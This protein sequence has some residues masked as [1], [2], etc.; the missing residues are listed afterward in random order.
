MNFK[1]INTTEFHLWTDVLHAKTLSCQAQNPWDRG[2]YVRWCIITGWTV[3]E[4]VFRQVLNDES[5]GY[6]FKEDVDRAIKNLGLPSFNWGEGI[7]QRILA[8]KDTRKNFVHTNLEQ[9]KLFLDTSVAI[10]Y[11]K[12]I[13]DGILEIH[14]YTRTPIPQWILYD[15]DRG[16][17]DGSESGIHIL[18]ERQGATKEDPQSIIVSYIYKGK[19]YPTEVLPANSDYLKTVTDMI[20]NFRSPIT[21]I[22]VYQEGKVIFETTLQMRGSF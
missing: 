7:W 19:E 10:D 22:K 2:S 6:R 4:M 9:N 3:L 20:T 14:K 5:I 11:V 1:H 15:D 12:G 8:L 18:I 16:W 13:Q 21:G 17:D